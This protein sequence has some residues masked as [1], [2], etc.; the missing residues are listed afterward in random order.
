MLV[1][2]EKPPERPAV[3]FRLRDTLLLVLVSILSQLF[4][5]LMSSNLM[6]FSFSSTRH[7]RAP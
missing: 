3:F 7:D 4:L 1:T 5:S 6:L 2:K